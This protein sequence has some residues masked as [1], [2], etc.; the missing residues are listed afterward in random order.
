MTQQSENDRVRGYLLAQSERHDWPALWPR[1][2]G[3]R[4]ELL[5][6][7]AALSEEQADFKPA[8]GEWSIRDCLA[9]VLHASRGTLAR[10]EAL[11]AGS[12]VAAAAPQ[13]EADSLADLRAQLIADSSHFAGILARLPE[14]PN[15]ELTAGHAV[16]GE[17]NS[18]AWF[19]FQRLHDSDHLG[20]IRAVK[21]AS[22]YPEA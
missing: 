17:L 11:A 22:G 18:R 16:F 19:L 12:V 20:Q 4:I 21:E 6:E 8:P 13:T 2:V 3:P 5:A 10:V 7:T 1:V 14:Q 9:H 15:L